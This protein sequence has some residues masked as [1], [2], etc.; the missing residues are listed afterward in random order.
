MI[1]LCCSTLG[2]LGAAADGDNLAPGADAGDTYDA[3]DAGG[4]IAEAEAGS[5]KG[6]VGLVA[7][8][9]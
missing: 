2:A 3:A 7:R 8:R 6:S 9:R 5:D 4:G 1:F